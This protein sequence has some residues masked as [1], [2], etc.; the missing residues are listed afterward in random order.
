MMHTFQSNSLSSRRTRACANMVTYIRHSALTERHKQPAY[1]KKQNLSAT[2][3]NRCNRSLK[4]LLKLYALKEMY[5]CF[6]N[7][8]SRDI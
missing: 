4:K 7:Q 8:V 1:V 6:P 3:Q 2:E 5:N